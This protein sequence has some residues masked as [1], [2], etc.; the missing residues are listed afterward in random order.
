M[1]F[2]YQF[3][4]GTL[5]LKREIGTDLLPTCLEVEV[6]EEGQW[7]NFAHLGGLNSFFIEEILRV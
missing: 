4:R 6:C 3:P 2:S 5:E 1:E 7:A